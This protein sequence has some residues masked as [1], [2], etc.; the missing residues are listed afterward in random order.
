MRTWQQQLMAM[1]L[2]LSCG[3]V[4]GACGRE[5]SVG[6]RQVLKPD[7]LSQ[8]YRV[9][10]F[11]TSSVASTFVANAEF[12]TALAVGEK[13]LALPMGDTLLVN[14]VPL[15][16]SE[17]S[18]TYTATGNGNPGTFVFVW[19]HEGTVFSNTVTVALYPPS[20][21]P[22][23]VSKSEEFFV[24]VPNVPSGVTV[25][26]TLNAGT[27]VAAPFIAV[28]IDVTGGGK[29]TPVSYDF[30]KLSEGPGALTLTEVSQG[31]LQAMT[32]RGGSTV[33]TVQFGF[34]VLIVE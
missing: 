33:S 4:L 22:T 30:S 34:N 15:T 1:S 7:D 19:T 24:Q 12:A 18:A 13:S 9:T 26:G 27:K 17:A 10:V 23:Y 8:V 2:I 5:L 14:G 11:A 28:P 20:P 6:P 29:S 3:W 25:T 31:G 32:A 16:Y 21:V